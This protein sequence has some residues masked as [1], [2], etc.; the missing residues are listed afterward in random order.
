MCD[1]LSR[2]LG[3]GKY[4]SNSERK[5]E[6]LNEWKSGPMLATGSF[7]AGVDV[8]R[9]REVIHVGLPYGLI[10]F[11]Q[12]SGRGGRGGEQVR[13][14]IFLRREEFNKLKRTRPEELKEDE[15]V[16]RDFILDD[17]CRRLIRSGYMNGIE[18]A[19]RCEELEDGLLCDICMKRM[20]GSQRRIR[21]SNMDEDEEEGR[22]KRRKYEKRI[23]DVEMD[24]RE[25]QQ[26]LSSIEEFIS[27]LKGKCQ[28]CRIGEAMDS[29]DHDFN[30]C[31]GLNELLGEEYW[32][33]KKR[34]I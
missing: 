15:R 16:M 12:E 22:R 2:K 6:T 11:D 17:E 10:D 4:Y 23:E 5:Q 32:K 20:N 28:A 26:R 25:E 27:E 21:Q 7:G 29:C 9:I 30:D 31:G 18:G 3:C 8:N 1:D 13:S 24:I 14:T 19:M 34:E 33:F